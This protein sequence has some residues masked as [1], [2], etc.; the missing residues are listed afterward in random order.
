MLAFNNKHK[1]LNILEQFGTYNFYHISL[2]ASLLFATRPA[3]TIQDDLAN[4]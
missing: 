2:L 3:K 4:K 1:S